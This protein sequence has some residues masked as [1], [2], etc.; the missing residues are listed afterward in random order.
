MKT[1]ST[2]IQ[3]IDDFATRRETAGIRFLRDFEDD[4]PLLSYR[5][6]HERIASSAA[7]FREQGITRGS[8]VVFPFETE[9]ESVAA[10][11][12][13]MSIGAVPFMARPPSGMPK[14]TY[15][16]FLG[17]L[18]T[19]FKARHVLSVLSLQHLGELP[20][21][22][23]TLPPPG[24]K[25]KA[26]A[27]RPVIAPG[28]VAFVQF[29]S[30]S[31][32]FPK[33]VPV[34][35][36]GLLDNVGMA[37][38]LD[39][40]K[41]SDVGSSWL[42][43][44]HNMGLVGGLLSPVVA[45]HE[46]LLVPPMQFALAPLDWLRFLSRSRTEMSIIPNF[47]IDF[48]LKHL[49]GANPAELGDLDLSALRM[50]YLGSEPIN[51]PNLRAFE[52]ILAP[53]GLRETALKPA[54]GM[55]EAVLVVSSVPQAKVDGDREAISVGP[56]IPEFTIRLRTEDGAPC[57]DGEI[58]EIE[59][60][61]GTLAQGYFEHDAPL[62]NGD[63]FYSTGDLGLIDDGELYILGRGND[64]FK[65]NATSYFA[66]EIEQIIGR[67]PFVTPGQLAAVQAD[68][69]LVVLLESPAPL[70]T[71]LR[72]EQR[73]KV[74]QSVNE[75][76]GIKVVLENILFV[77]P[78]QIEKTSSGKIRRKVIADNYLRGGVA[79]AEEAASL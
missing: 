46:L 40:R 79:L 33:G 53:F 37:H 20:L 56:V 71:A 63:G 14:E 17:A 58:G 30:G 57:K 26:P 61:G 50:V 6:L 21:A 77:R 29:S 16:Q 78:G 67:L 60:R 68:G 18:A 34:T 39:G 44:Y 73:R 54:Y 4:A 64:R 62:L 9:G 31:T 45:G 23:L 15:L 32:G 3:V 10:F 2:L 28:D 19:K 43:L 65:L 47:A 27:P 59:L 51:I 1:Y 52:R 42:P 49:A 74:A 7:F 11:F 25:A 5:E 70:P 13:L 36:Q 24:Y 76:F 75:A 12:A 38:A 8:R 35:H 55:A 69:R 41:D 72:D 66:S 22:R 48:T